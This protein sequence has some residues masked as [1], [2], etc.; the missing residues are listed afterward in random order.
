MQQIC[1][2]EKFSEDYTPKNFTSSA[3][4]NNPSPICEGL[5]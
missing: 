3:T 5:I 4:E 2:T 1:I